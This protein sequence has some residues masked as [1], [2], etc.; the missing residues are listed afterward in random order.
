M[1]S[2]RFFGRRQ[3]DA[4]LQA[5]LDS[6]LEITTAEYVAAGMPP[7]AARTAA[8]RKLGNPTLVRE[9]VYFMNTLPTVEALA[10]A[11]RYWRRTVRRE[12]VFAATA[13]VTLA[14]GIGAATAVFSVVD[15]V[16]IKPLPYPTADQLVT[17]RHYAPGMGFRDA[18]NM[19][20]SM[21]YTYR[22]ESRV[23]QSI[24][25]WSP[26]SATV[27]GLAEPERA[28]VLDVTFGTLQALNVP[29]LLGRWITQEDDAPG[30][31]EV[32]LLGHGYWQ[33][34]FTADRDVIGRTLTVDLRPR[35]IIGVMPPSFFRL[36]GQD[37]DL[38]IP[39]QLDPHRLHLGDLGF[40]GL[41]RLKPGVTLAEANS[42]VARVLPTWLRS[43]P[44]PSATFSPEVFRQARFTPALLPLKEEV[45]GSIGSVLWL[46]L[47]AVG[48]VLLIACANVANLFLVQSESRR[49]E[50][51]IRLALGAGRAQI[52]REA[53]AESV[54]FGV[55]GGC[56]GLALAD[57]GL[58]LLRFLE[59]ATLPRLDEI[60]LDAPV[61]AFAVAVS[62]LS[63]LLAGLLPALQRAGTPLFTALRGAGHCAVA[64]RE[65]NRAR[66]LLVVAQVSLALVLLV[67]SGL[68]LRTF[69]QIRRV[70]PGFTHP[71]Q[72]Q[73]FSLAIPRSQIQQPERVVR[74]LHDML[75]HL[76]A[77]P[78]VSAAGLAN[79][80]P[81]DDTKNQN[82]VVAE[83]SSPE[84]AASARI[85]TFKFVSPGFLAATGT[86]LIAGRDIDWNDIDNHRPVVMLSDNLARELWGTPSLAV[87]K[88]IREFGEQL[89]WRDVVGVVQ[90]VHDDG[91][92]SQA[93]ATV[94]W[95]FAIENFLGQS[96]NV[97]RNVTF[98]VRGNGA[99]TEAFVKQ[100]RQTV[101]AVNP[102]SPL[103]GIH[104]L[105]D[106]YDRSMSQTAFA[107]V[108]F[109]VAGSMALV[110][111]LVGVY[112]VIAYAVAQRSSEIGI[113][114]A[115]GAP[116]S[117]VKT[118]F[119]RQGLFLTASGIALGICVA[120][121]VSRLL[122]SLLF[123]VTPFDPITYIASATVLLF[124]ALAAS[125]IPAR[126]AAAVDP[127]QTLRAE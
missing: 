67:T 71:E 45:L 6:Y 31:P 33:R 8:R 15:A 14:L 17:I 23:F 114:V 53:L 13:M 30:A 73:A 27:T 112:G 81:M 62:L 93:P 7:E 3:A 9:E 85:R 80:L 49:H 79:S 103:V 113:R 86:R 44:G 60:S 127:I 123:G 1:N 109:A 106:T 10:S 120:A 22:A 101:A 118:M 92:Q 61:V 64:T 91:A 107:L 117:A 35:R 37:P 42:D 89:R 99:G 122:S 26:A 55:A 63:C 12:P 119:T 40:P 115:L 28:R 90:D 47:G 108:M 2:R 124:A 82:P 50:R 21:L 19:S 87:G 57:S 16:L 125:Y 32:V 110:L 36:M 104:T 24:G 25:G 20:P 46:L 100:V 75:E 41:A 94:Y 78:G 4:D 43:W 121:G 83:N 77:M 126:R 51:S 65:R 84:A 29:P 116:A 52:L 95:P 34:R 56:L 88:R 69:Q 70:E 105:A 58:R 54:L 5:E 76:A 74:M 39:L 97:Q 38:F 102:N 18:I 11:F 59:P 98:A 66:N 68:M 111:G 96:L 72:V 48:I